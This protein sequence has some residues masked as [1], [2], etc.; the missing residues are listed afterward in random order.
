PLSRPLMNASALAAGDLAKK[1]ML[2]D[3][4]FLVPSQYVTNW[5]AMTNLYKEYCAD[6]VTG[7]KP[8]SAFDEFVEKWNKAGGAEVTKYAQTVLK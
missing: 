7:K 8:I 4:T 1:Y 5:D 6:I 3:H 2:P